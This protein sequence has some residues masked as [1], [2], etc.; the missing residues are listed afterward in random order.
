MHY[1]GQSEVSLS[2]VLALYII[3]LTSSCHSQK[4]SSNSRILCPGLGHFF[5]LLKIRPLVPTGCKVNSKLFCM[6]DPYDPTLASS[7]GISSF[8]CSHRPTALATQNQTSLNLQILP[9]TSHCLEFSTAAAHHTH[10]VPA[11][12]F[13][14]SLCLYTLK[15]LLFCV[16]SSK[17]L[18]S[19]PV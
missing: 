18:L 4:T 10:T 11:W 12:L 16:T 17:T 14:S 8:A 13:F 6:T 5:F 1:L 19:Q 3:M 7:A 2:S 15:Y 9:P